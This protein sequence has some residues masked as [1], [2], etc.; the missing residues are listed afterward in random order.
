MKSES[1]TPT[2]QVFWEPL[3]FSKL[4]E[5]KP[6]RSVPGESFF[7]HGRAQQWIVKDAAVIWWRQRL[8]APL[9][10]LQELRGPG[11]VTNQIK[12]PVCCLRPGLQSLWSGA[13]W[14]SG[15]ILATPPC[16]SGRSRG[17]ACVPRGQGRPRRPEGGGPWPRVTARRPN[18]CENPGPAFLQR[19]PLAGCGAWDGCGGSGRWEAVQDD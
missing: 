1:E 18:R 10:T 9:L 5:E 6:T 16:G 8:K 11:E 14:A 4:L 17:R 3:T 15:Q 12:F 7:R 2:S 13:W 19:L